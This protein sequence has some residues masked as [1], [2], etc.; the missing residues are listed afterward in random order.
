M[1]NIPYKETK[2]E[3]WE[4]NFGVKK[5]TWGLAYFEHLLKYKELMPIIWISM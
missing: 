1:W 2:F 5:E 3:G 4:W